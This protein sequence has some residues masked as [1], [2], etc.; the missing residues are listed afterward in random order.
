MMSLSINEYYVAH[1]QI[2]GERSLFLSTTQQNV[3]WIGLTMSFS[4]PFILTDE[5]ANL[6]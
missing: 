5:E 3:P 4:T 6:Q 1:N 2:Q